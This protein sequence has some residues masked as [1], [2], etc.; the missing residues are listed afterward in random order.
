[1]D[2]SQLPDITQDEPIDLSQGASLS[3]KV[4]IAAPQG[5][6]KEA[7]AGGEN[8]AK[9]DDIAAP[10]QSASLSD[11][12]GTDHDALAHQATQYLQQYQAGDPAIHKDDLGLFHRITELA[13]EYNKAANAEDVAAQNQPTWLRA[14]KSAVGGAY[15]AGQSIGNWF[16]NPTMPEAPSAET[17]A[18]LAIAPTLGPLAPFLF[19]KQVAEAGQG[20]VIGV[21]KLPAIAS[22]LA[23]GAAELS[24]AGILAETTP[25]GRTMMAQG[26][27]VGDVL[28]HYTNTAANDI[29]NITGVSHDTVASMIGENISLAALPF[30]ELNTAEAAAAAVDRSAN[31][32][33][34]ALGGAKWVAAKAAPTAVGAAK[35]ATIDALLRKMGVGGGMDEL[36]AFWGGFGGKSGAGNAEIANKIATTVM[37][38]PLSEIAQDAATVA[39]KPMGTTTNEA[40]AGA[41][42]QKAT[43]L[44]EA[45]DGLKT[46]LE[47]KDAKMVDELATD[48]S[49]KYAMEDLSKDA[50]KVREKMQ[51]VAD[52]NAKAT[53]I[54]KRN[55]IQKLFDSSVRMFGNMGLHAATGTAIGAAFTGSQAPTGATDEAVGQ[56]AVLGG[57]LGLATAPFATAGGMR[58]LRMTKGRQALMSIAD[59]A[60][61]V[62]GDGIDITDLS[63][64]EQAY[65]KTLGGGV[66]WAGKKVYVHTP[67]RL[68][69]VGGVDMSVPDADPGHGFIDANGDIHLNSDTIPKRAGNH[70]YTHFTQRMFGEMLQKLAPEQMAVFEKEY[71]DALSSTGRTRF[72]SRA[73]RDAEIGRLVL[74]NTPL[75]MFYGGEQGGDVVRR[76]L[77]GLTGNRGVQHWGGF[78]VP[79]RAE[80]I[81]AMR[82]RF[83]K[84][85]E[86]QAGLKPGEA[87][88]TKPPDVPLSQWNADQ[89]AQFHRGFEFFKQQGMTDE[90]AFKGM[91]DELDFLPKRK[92]GQSREDQLDHAW[93]SYYNMVQEQNARREPDV[94][95]PK[96]KKPKWY[97][98]TT[99]QEDARMR[100]LLPPGQRPKL[101]KA[102]AEKPMEMKPFKRVYGWLGPEGKY[103]PNEGGMI[104]AETVTY[105]LNKQGKV[106]TKDYYRNFQ[107]DIDSGKFNP[108][109]HPYTGS[110][111]YAYRQGWENN[112]KRLVTRGEDMFVHYP[113]KY[114]LTD[115]DVEDLGKLAYEHGM[116]HVVRDTD[117]TE[118]TIW[119][120]PALENKV[121]GEDK[122]AR[123]FKPGAL[124]ETDSG[125]DWL[126]KPRKGET[127]E[128]QVQDAWEHYAASVHR[129][130][131]NRGPQF[132]DYDFKEK[133]P[134]WWEP[135]TL[136]EEI[137]M[138][139]L[140]PPKQRPELAKVE[141]KK[142]ARLKEV[143]G[144]L[145]PE[146]EYMENRDGD[147]HADT[148]TKRLEGEDAWE[149]EGYHGLYGGMTEAYHAGFRN[150]YLRLTNMGREMYVHYPGEYGEIPKTQLN[151][152][153][154]LAEKHGITRITRD[155]E[156]RSE[157]LWKSPL[158]E[159]T[160]DGLTTT[161]D[162]NDSDWMPKSREGLSP[163]LNAGKPDES[164]FF[165]E[166]HGGVYAIVDRRRPS[167][168]IHISPD[169][170]A[171]KT[172]K[173]E[174]DRAWFPRTGSGGVW[175]ST[176]V[177]GEGQDMRQALAKQVGADP[178]K[179]F[180]E[181]PR[182]VQA[183]IANHLMSIGEADYM[184]KE[185]DVRGYIAST[186][187]HEHSMGDI[188]GVY[189]ANTKEFDRRSN[190]MSNQVNQ[191]MTPASKGQEN[192]TFLNPKIVM[193]GHYTARNGFNIAPHELENAVLDAIAEGNDGLVV[194]SKS[195]L[196]NPHGP[197]GRQGSSVP[198]GDPTEEL[199]FAIAHP[200]Q[201]DWEHPSNIYVPLEQT[202]LS[203]EAPAEVAAPKPVEIKDAWNKYLRG[204]DLSREERAAI[205]GQS[206]GEY[207][208]DMRDPSES[209][210]WWKTGEE[211]PPYDEG[212]SDFNPGGP[213]DE[214]PWKPPP[215]D[216]YNYDNEDFKRDFPDEWNKGAGERGEGDNPHYDYMPRRGFFL[217]RPEEG[218]AEPQPVVTDSSFLP[219]GFFLKRPKEGLPPP[220]P[221]FNPKRADKEQTE[222]T[223]EQAVQQGKER[224]F[225]KRE[226]E[227][228]YMPR[229]ELERMLSMSEDE[230]SNYMWN[231]GHIPE[232]VEPPQPPPPDPQ[233]AAE[234]MPRAREL[235]QDQQKAYDDWRVAP[236]GSPEKR[237]AKERLQKINEQL[238]KLDR[239]SGHEQ[240]E[241]FAPK[242]KIEIRNALVLADEAHRGEKRTGSNLPYITH[243]MAVAELVN[244]RLKP[245]AILHDAL[246][247]G[248]V[249]VKDMKKMG[250]SS[251]TLMAVQALTRQP[252]ETYFEYIDRL[253]GNPDARDIKVADI[254]H[255]LSDLPS[256]SPL[257]K[258]YKKAMDMLIP[259]D[260]AAIDALQSNQKDLYGAARDLP[261]GTPVG[262]RID[263]SAYED[264]DQY[265][266][267]VHDQKRKPVGDRIGYD[268][269]SGVTDPTFS[270]NQK[271]AAKVKE[272]GN[273]FPMATV[274]GGY[275]PIREFPEDI[276]DYKMVGFNPV[277]HSY[278]YEKGTGKPVIAGDEAISSGNT[279]FVKNPV[280]GNPEDFDYMPTWEGV[281]A[282]NLEDKYPAPLVSAALQDPMGNLT[283]G[284]SHMGAYI[285]HLQGIIP[286]E[287]GVRILPGP[288][289]F[290]EGFVD[291]RGDFLNRI[292]AN[293]RALDIGQ[294][295]NLPRNLPLTSEL[296][297]EMREFMPKNQKE[298]GEF[299]K[300]M[301]RIF[302]EAITPTFEKDKAGNYKVDKET[303]EFVPEERPWNLDQSPLYKEVNGG[304]TGEAKQGLLVKQPDG[305]FKT[306]T[307]DEMDKRYVQ[308]LAEKIADEYRNKWSKDPLAMTAR[309]W[310]R[311]FT[312][313]VAEKMGPENAELFAQLL[314]TTSPGN[315]AMVNF[316]FALEAYNNYVSG[317][318]DKVLEQF[319]DAYSKFKLGTLKDAEGNLITKPGQFNQYLRDNN[320]LA[321]Q[322]SGKKLGKYS[323]PA[324]Y[325]LAGHFWQRAAGKKVIQFVKNLSGVDIHNPTID[326][327][328]AR[329]ADRLS[330]EGMTDKPWRDLPQNEA[331]VGDRDFDLAS[332]AYKKAAKMVGEN[333][334]DLQAIAW[335]GEKI[336]YGHRGWIRGGPGASLGDFRPLIEG[337]TRKTG[338]LHELEAPK[339]YKVPY[340][341]VNR[342]Q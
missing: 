260:Q 271:G 88:T 109:D 263:I 169:L 211:P 266:V 182:S 282:E 125:T 189:A 15:K 93:E 108:D 215:L 114:K 256:D 110:M 219:R 40:L 11:I 130:N 83:F 316:K 140:L 320:I 190:Q 305:T 323:L 126:P 101:A 124:D 51:Q 335:F 70:E 279:V 152:L 277:K 119:T 163:G 128:Q 160:D 196:Y 214:S 298:L 328:A 311:E 44:Q 315:S 254:M 52:L 175:D 337:S 227:T 321:M 85:G 285:K 235:Y 153:I 292:P 68:A 105:I 133:K 334:T 56:G 269:I 280:Y 157:P 41:V 97:D 222:L 111:E 171:L 257:R 74:N 53:T 150:D 16:R 306:V 185:N 158:V 59:K 54:L 155:T 122:Y 63:P 55:D 9:L 142:V 107:H 71:G 94:E 148:I 276:G 168:V 296:F 216:S 326:L 225:L 192:V 42:K 261:K 60:G 21:G 293:N 295:R 28:Q 303:G 95:L 144:W 210:E 161:F 151:K 102:E 69:E 6:E 255:N 92:P 4:D 312:K 204:E 267:A 64:A 234:Y 281:G 173:A 13:G 39:T 188:H 218:L 26:R 318:Y 89:A 177:T 243:P 34:N 231:K 115:K 236:I 30:G 172:R 32:V 338:T 330:H 170:D 187:L 120:N 22:Q 195:A 47:S 233:A 178:K 208:K 33:G 113:D 319:R 264:H 75:E 127:R 325:T 73:N 159:T 275:N 228:D 8:I 80:D 134:K 18:K 308:A 301:R 49:Y 135:V 154:E 220:E 25:E 331:K 272:G 342:I 43:T 238:N 106:P 50:Q 146:G 258:R 307:Q 12:T 232:V 203:K 336:G 212:G 81:A 19:P 288:G 274:L 117:Q 207:T 241:E 184:P 209:Q 149:G 322:Q 2:T 96:E 273:K 24:P 191:Y 332:A 247:T 304:K 199:Q 145:S 223:W 327:W 166:K 250:M 244:D 48:G 174:M 17:V 291:K 183:A 3:P 259:S 10:E 340:A 100:S 61:N 262:D 35:A 230:L 245:A 176:F 294:L 242:N 14:A 91:A 104:H 90:Q 57:A 205:E 46:G 313:K 1:M 317:R 206:P 79:Y 180:Y 103:I 249:T 129:Q 98:P 132:E 297:N 217:K 123:T 324:M 314:S 300:E 141:P 82:G 84:A 87:M 248:K 283:T 197:Q 167:D 165:I 226:G 162:F 29:S 309:G 202:K 229:E 67:D 181:Q 299:Q 186:P 287:R 131:A 136:K 270:V 139:S 237:E 58:S 251:D 268:N 5:S 164:P 23:V 112:F 194:L 310:Y 286:D 156:S 116:E 333:V 198:V 246:E 329:T 20:A 201:V 284:K 77:S 240:A 65:V 147:I 45:V 138:R 143:Y 38:K 78:K 302:P 62:V 99:F 213:P 253:K 72:D 252:N 179:H 265:V 121:K 339:S 27:A 7:P 31:M 289:Y 76:M 290:Q 37:G 341:K 66:N 200:E 193:E 86:I 36:L 239:P 221:F 278:F 118:K 224:E 137:R